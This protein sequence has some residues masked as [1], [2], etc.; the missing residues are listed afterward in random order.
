MLKK[1]RSKKIL[2]CVGLGLLGVGTIAGTTTYHYMQH[3][4]SQSN[5]GFDADGENYNYGDVIDLPSNITFKKNVNSSTQNLTVKATV[6]PESATNKELTWSLEWVDGGSHGTPTDYVTI[7]PSADTHSC[8]IVCNKGFNYQLKVVITSKQNNSVKTSCTL[9]YY[10]TFANDNFYDLCAVGGPSGGCQLEFLSDQ[11][12][13]EYSDSP[14]VNLAY[15]GVDLDNTKPKE[16]C[17]LDMSAI[18]N[19]SGNSYWVGTTGSK[20]FTVHCDW[21][22]DRQGIEDICNKYGEQDD[23][24][25]SFDFTATSSNSKIDFS[26]IAGNAMIFNQGVGAVN[27]GLINGTLTCSYQVTDG[28]DNTITFS[29][30]YKNAKCDSFTQ[31]SK[32]TISSSSYIF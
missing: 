19:D 25:G 29:V 24:S 7:T 10:Y 3:K 5:T 1:L 6:L 23:G 18:Y 20:D 17:L 13:N 27:F 11:S 14:Y 16:I 4:L 12:Y 22:F 32:I 31:V 28:R 26:E 15:Y 8:T 2:A 9:D 21:S 30:D